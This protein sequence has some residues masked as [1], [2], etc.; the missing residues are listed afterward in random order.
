[1]EEAAPDNDRIGKHV[2]SH[3]TASVRFNDFWGRWTQLGGHGDPTK[4]TA[5]KGEIIFNAA[6]DGLVELVQE[7]KDW[8]IEE[9]EDQHSNQV[10]KQIRW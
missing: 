3:S 6:V 2:T 5:E 10:Q 1:M 4:G 8:P 7:I 9:R